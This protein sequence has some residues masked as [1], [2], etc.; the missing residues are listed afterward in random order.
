[1]EGSLINMVIVVKFCAPNSS[2]KIAYANS[3]NLDQTAP[4]GAV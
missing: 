1:M 4:E 2:D 3:A